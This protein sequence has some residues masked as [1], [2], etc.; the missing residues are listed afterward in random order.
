MKNTGIVP[1]NIPLGLA[2]I[3]AH[4]PALRT[5][6]PH[7][8][9]ETVVPT[10]SHLLLT[11]PM[12]YGT[13]T[14][15]EVPLSLDEPRIPLTLDDYM[16]VFRKGNEHLEAMVA[17]MDVCWDPNE[18]DPRRLHNLY[19]R[20]LIT[21]YVAKFSE[22]GR[23]IEDA[24]ENRR[25]LTYAL[26]G[27]S[28]IENAATLRYF[29][30]HKYEEVFKKG[31]VNLKALLYID[32][33]HLR[34]SRF[35]WDSFLTG[36]F[37]KLHEDALASVRAKK[38]SKKGAAKPDGTEAAVNVSTC[39]EKWAKESPG[40]QVVYDLFCDM[41]H[42]NIGSAFLVSSVGPNGLYFA[43]NRG[44]SVGRS[45]FER[46]FPLLVSTTQKPFGDS[47]AMLIGTIWEEDEITATS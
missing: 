14:M 36:D 25:Y 35:D 5:T 2:A 28:L 37:Q 23:S 34:G 33:H 46:S 3:A 38:D 18:P 20:N 21:C 16:S 15:W 12:P 11:A 45:I 22:L 4:A 27:R 32:D 44:D 41:V 39:I 19:V 43:Q 6:R 24:I 40:V 31:E 30:R 1:L 42:P 7:R 13:M 26:C 29:V 47:L 9:V 17:G 8:Q 10:T